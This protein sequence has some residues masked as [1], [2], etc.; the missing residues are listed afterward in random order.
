MKVSELIYKLVALED[1]HGKDMEVKILDETCPI[2]IDGIVSEW[3]EEVILILTG[4]E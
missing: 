3:D 4:T 2:V 1:I